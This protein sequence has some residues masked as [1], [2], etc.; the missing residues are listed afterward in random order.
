MDGSQSEWKRVLVNAL[1]VKV[2]APRAPPRPASTARPRTCEEPSWKQPLVRQP[3]PAWRGA[4]RRQELRLGGFDVPAGNLEEEQ[5]LARALLPRA[6][7]RLARA[8]QRRRGAAEHRP[9]PGFRRRRQEGDPGLSRLRALEAEQVRA[10][11]LGLR[12]SRNAGGAARVRENQQIAQENREADEFNENIAEL[13]RQ[14]EE[15]RRQLEEVP[16]ATNEPPRR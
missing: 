11:D 14:R 7:L 13:E 4:A 16:G 5:R 10:G 12:T 2:G 1:K 3:P 15:L 8:L 9:L 6:G